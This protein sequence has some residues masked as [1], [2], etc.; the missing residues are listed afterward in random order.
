MIRPAADFLRF[1]GEGRFMIQR[2]RS[3][4]RYVFYPRVVEP[5][6]GASDLEWV[7]ASGRGT[8]YAVTVQREKPPKADTNVVLVELEEGPRLMSRVDGVAPTDV[9]IGMRVSA[10][11]I[12]EESDP[13]VIFVPDEGATHA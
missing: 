10:R 5:V 3:S 1:L 13:F 12:R 6:T 4:G 9:T 11:I 8:V 7:A 2:S